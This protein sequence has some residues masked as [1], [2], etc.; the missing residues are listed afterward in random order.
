MKVI[1]YFTN[2]SPEQFCLGIV[3]AALVIRYVYEILTDK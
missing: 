3:I 1:D 2:A